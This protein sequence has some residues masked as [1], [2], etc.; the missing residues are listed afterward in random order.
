MT[1]ADPV[2]ARLISVNLGLARPLL[3]SGRRVLSAIGKEP[4]AGP[5]A[6]ARLGLAGDEQADLSVH[7]GL[8]KAVYGYP[9]EHLAFW[10]TK[11]LEHSVSLWDEVLPSGL[12]GENLSLQ[13]LLEAQVW[14]GDEL[15]FPGCVLRVTAPREP[16]YKFNA[17]MGYPQAARDMMLAGCCG[18]YLAVKQGGTIEAGQY[19]TLV[20]G[21]RGLSIAE[22]FQ[23]R[24]IKHLR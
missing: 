23:A 2:A 10:Q 16:C 13:G 15:H 21:Q 3:A 1:P 24:R 4:V 22:A 17:V 14:V 9:S 19:G 11:R 5:V 18:F 6:V 8:D 12:V 7:G 20:P